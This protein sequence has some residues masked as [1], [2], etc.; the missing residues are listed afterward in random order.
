VFLLYDYTVEQRQRKVLSTA[1]RTNAIVSSLFPSVV[2]DR[3]YPTD[4][5]LKDQKPF[6]VASSKATLKSFLNDGTSNVETKDASYDIRPS[7]APVADLF[8][9]CVECPG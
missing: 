4:Q 3:L 7:S 6:R 8:P 9:E 1:M 5:N 2:R